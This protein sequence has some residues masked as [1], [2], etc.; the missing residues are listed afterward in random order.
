MLYCLVL[1]FMNLL[2]AVYVDYFYSNLSKDGIDEKA[3]EEAAKSPKK[4]S[5]LSQKDFVA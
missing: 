1:F 3:E 5:Q 4:N 2:V